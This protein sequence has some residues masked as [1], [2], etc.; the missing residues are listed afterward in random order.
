[1]VRGR[2]KIK[3]EG[4]SVG[5][6]LVPGA[7]VRTKGKKKRGGSVGEKNW[8]FSS[9]GPNLGVPALCGRSGSRAGK[10]VGE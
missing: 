2:K 10:K 1:M 5:P 8:G 9:H 6:V 7:G 3:G 4:E